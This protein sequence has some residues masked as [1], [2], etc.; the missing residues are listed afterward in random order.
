MSRTEMVAHGRPER[1]VGGSRTSPARGK[2]LTGWTLRD[3]ARHVYYFPTFHLAAGAAVK[4]HTGHGTSGA[5]S[6]YWGSSL[7]IWN[8]TGDSATLKEANGVDDDQCHYT[9]AADP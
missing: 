4:I 2:T 1:R 6:R 3:A 7:Y 8:N 9:M 5:H